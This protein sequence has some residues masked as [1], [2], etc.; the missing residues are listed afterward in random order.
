[1]IYVYR[2]YDKLSESWIKSW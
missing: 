1:V 2:H